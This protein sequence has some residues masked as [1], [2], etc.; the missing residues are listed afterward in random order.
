MFRNETVVLTLARLFFFGI[1][2]YFVALLAWM[3]CGHAQKLPLELKMS[4]KATACQ[5]SRIV[6]MCFFA[7]LLLSAHW[8]LALLVHVQR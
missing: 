2:F 7:P 3:A 4:V 1:F 6:L 5:A 8:G